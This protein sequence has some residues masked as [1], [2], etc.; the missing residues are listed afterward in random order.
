MKRSLR[1][2][3]VVAGGVGL[4]SLFVAFIG[5]PLV[6]VIFWPSPDFFG[7]DGSGIMESM[8]SAQ[9]LAKTT[10][11]VSFGSLAVAGICFAYVLVVLAG[12]FIGPSQEQ[13]D[14]AP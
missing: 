10:S 6:S 14:R 12:S 3:L 1:I 5:A 2:R 7:D 9:Q 4:F 11:F 13:R 8:S